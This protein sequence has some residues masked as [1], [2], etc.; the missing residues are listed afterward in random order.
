[1]NIDFGWK[2]SFKNLNMIFEILILDLVYF[3]KF[4]EKSS[5]TPYDK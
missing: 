3:D 4:L 2:G 1:L 5:L